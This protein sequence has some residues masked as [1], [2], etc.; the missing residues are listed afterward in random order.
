MVTRD[1]LHATLQ[2]TMPKKL[3]QVEHAE[4]PLP[5][6]GSVLVLNTEALIGP[7]AEAMLQALH[8]R[9]TGGI[10]A[11]LEVLAEKGA[12]KFMSTYYVGYGHKSIGDCGTATV[13][14]EGVWPVAA[15]FKWP[16]NNGI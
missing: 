9:S 12:D 3:S 4:H 15:I 11:H 5:S 8:S 7:E 10:R 6:G 2:H 16:T 14:V 13:F 1:V